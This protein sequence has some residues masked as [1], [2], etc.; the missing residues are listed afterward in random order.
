M[1]AI[2]SVT[3]WARGATAVGLFTVLLVP[4]GATAHAG[5][6]PAETGPGA[7]FVDAATVHPRDLQHLP[8]PVP[9]RAYLQRDKGHAPDPQPSARAAEDADLRTECAKQEA[10]AKTKTG[11]LK[12]RF[13][14]CYKRH[15]DLVLRDRNNKEKTRGRLI[16]DA[17]VLG[18]AHDGTRQVDFVASVEDIKVAADGDEDAKEWR[19]GQH[20][21]TTIDA[22][23][24]DPDAKLTGPTVTK[25][26]ELLGVWDPRPSWTLVY[27]S[28]DKGPQHAQGNMQRVLAVLDMTTTVNSPNVDPY[29]EVGSY[30]SNFRFDYAGPTAGKHKGAVFTQARVE[31]VMSQ[32]DPAV[33]ESALHIYDA[34]KRPERTFPS[35]LG[36]SVPG[37]KEPLHRLIDPKKIDLQRDRSVKE[38]EKIWG[39]YKGTRLQCDEYPF[40]STHEGSLK[41]NNRFSV[42]LIEGTDNEAG[43]RALNAMYI[44]N[45]V[46]DGDPF[47]MK[48]IP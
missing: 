46:L 17:W 24:S 44:S 10:A 12:S 26:D 43:G 20:F 33:N 27:T 5:P 2:T 14:N 22:S 25:R 8:D 48:I 45:R 30:I 13:E 18:F 6:A 42:R 15:Y 7:H 32:K 11:W 31:L 1:T 19:L 38:C 21:S 3:R 9:L 35:F 36:K 28:P 39:S 34:L 47:F 23:S 4:I 29:V 16:F 37:E 40:A 41:G